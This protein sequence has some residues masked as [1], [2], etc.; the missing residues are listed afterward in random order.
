M[1]LREKEGVGE[2]RSVRRVKAMGSGTTGPSGRR[3]EEGREG[4]GRGEEGKGRERKGE[5]GRG[6]E[7]EGEEGKMKEGIT[8][9]YTYTVTSCTV[10]MQGLF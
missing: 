5:E 3:R 6:R 9:I 8:D 10:K 4:E 7:G 1:Q 2:E